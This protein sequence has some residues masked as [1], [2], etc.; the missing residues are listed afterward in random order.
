MAGIKDVARHAGVSIATV[1]MVLN[2]KES[3]SQ[4]TRDKVLASVELLDYRPNSLARSF[5]VG[6]T[7]AIGVLVPS[8][9]NPVFPTIVHSIEEACR[10]TGK[11][12]ILCSYAVDPVTSLGFDYLSDLYDR[13]VDGV[14][15]CGIPTYSTA[16]SLAKAKTT[17][18]NYI[19]REIPLVFLSDQR[20]YEYFLGLFDL[21]T[22]NHGRLI[23]LVHVD[24]ERAAHKVVSHFI[25]LGHRRIAIVTESTKDSFPHNIPFLQKLR[26]YQRALEE[27]DI[28]FDGSLIVAAPENFIG[29]EQAF[30]ALT[31]LT[32]P[33]TAIFVTGDVSALGVLRAARQRGVAVPEDLSV[34]GFDNIPLASYSNPTL[35][36]ISQP[37]EQMAG[38]AYRRLTLAMR[39]EPAVPAQVEFNTELIIRESCR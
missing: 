12:V 23:Q 4:A 5:K 36:T 26:G 29:G 14:I 38:E 33:P 11:R 7:N 34:C 32:D 22:Q 6:T 21:N 27:N 8:I 16:D 3:I 13:M 30:G 31:G 35:S 2:H 25:S 28:P 39:K 9:V 37:I 19:T 24:R 15:I 20:Q 17:I 18:R 10:E 1:S